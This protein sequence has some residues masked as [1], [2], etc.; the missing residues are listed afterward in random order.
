MTLRQYELSSD[1]SELV[2]WLPIDA[3]LKVGAKLTLKEIPGIIWL[4][5]KVYETEMSHEALHFIRGWK[6]GGIL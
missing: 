1:G 3:R 6:V 4:I 5:D 2:C